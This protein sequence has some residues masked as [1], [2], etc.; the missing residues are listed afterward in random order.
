MLD[1]RAII[2]STSTTSRQTSLELPAR[3]RW[4]D[5][6]DSCERC[7]V[8]ALKLARPCLGLMVVASRV[9]IV[10]APEESQ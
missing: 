5:N 2:S 4:S 6:E 10:E 1:T 8:K 9:A 3:D 7:P